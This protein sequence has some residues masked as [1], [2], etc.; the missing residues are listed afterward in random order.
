M[1]SIFP[2]LLPYALV[3]PFVVRV[4]V[5]LALFYF[6]F[7][8]FSHTSWA[9]AVWKVFHAE[10]FASRMSGFAYGASGA[11]IFIGF[12]TQ[13]AVLIPIPFLLYDMYGALKGARA[14]PAEH[15]VL[16]GLVIF[17][18]I[19]LLFSGAGFFAIDLPL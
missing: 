6:A 12:F 13:A 5:A 3:A 17:A 14:T 4:G 10:G 18:L 11:F 16:R 19:S 7:A 8:H 1:L 15:I 9:H 2:D